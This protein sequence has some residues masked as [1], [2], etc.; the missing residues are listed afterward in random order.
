M[1]Q[2][3]LIVAAIIIMLCGASYSFGRAS[4]IKMVDM[5]YTFGIYDAKMRPLSGEGGVVVVIKQVSYSDRLWPE[6]HW[7]RISGHPDPEGNLRGKAKFP[8]DPKV[9]GEMDRAANGK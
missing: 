2:R 6:E 3:W 7:S 9:T 8:L 1:K 5:H 4:K